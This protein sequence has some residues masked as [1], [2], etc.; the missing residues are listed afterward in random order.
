MSA[1]SILSP[2]G[3]DRWS[4]CVGSL[5]ACKGIPEDR[6]NNKPAALGTAKHSLTEWC[7][8]NNKTA[9]EGAAACMPPFE[10]SADGHTFK[11]DEEFITHVQ[12]AIDVVLRQPGDKLYEV[13]LD[14]AGVLG[15]PGQSGT[16]DVAI[17]DHAQSM[18]T[19]L[20]HKFGWGRV[21][22]FKNKQ[23]LI[24]L[25]ALRRKFG[26][27]FDFDKFRIIISQ[28]PLNSV[29]GED[30]IY[31]AQDLDQF[32][33][34]IRAKAVVAYEL[35]TMNNPGMTTANLH[36]DDKACEWCPIAGQCIARTKR[37]IDQFADLTGP[38]AVA[39]LT[40]SDAELGALMVKVE[41]TFK[42][43]MAEV[44]AEGYKRALAGADPKGFGWGMYTGRDGH[45][46]FIPGQEAKVATTLEMTLGD[47]M[48]EKPQLKSPTQ[49]EVSLKAAKAHELYAIVAKYVERPPGKPS[50]QRYRTDVPPVSAAPMMEFADVT[51]AATV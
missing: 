36:P 10:M 29:E 33:K 14:T 3:A 45:R 38:A 50:L 30:H 21:R 31:T 47:D 12:F 5:A 15:V 42:P 23:L 39:P 44:M 26:D 19:M 24:Y 22:A 34:E 46:R 28:P 48:Y 16:G 20:D 49:I 2:S 8:R 4:V 7:L 51:A 27:L 1:H 43:F 6:S 41:D 35:Y 13:K 25:C 18:L 32:E 9:A 37:I 11:V 40:L 17:I